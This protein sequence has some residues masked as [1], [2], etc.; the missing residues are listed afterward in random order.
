MSTTTF[1][2][3]CLPEM[4]VSKISPEEQIFTGEIF[5][6]IFLVGRNFILWIV[7]KKSQKLEPKTLKC[8]M[9]MF[10]YNH[11]H[12]FYSL[13]VTYSL[14]YFLKNFN[15]LLSDPFFPILPSFLF[16]FCHNTLFSGTEVGKVCSL[17]TAL[18]IHQKGTYNAK[19]HIS[20]T[21]KTIWNFLCLQIF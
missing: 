8:Q 13:F 4:F 17:E 11:E 19:Y 3:W 15:L 9:V 20:N 10:L 14:Q 7:V 16:I 2:M 21:Q 5:L 1:F 6:G 18:Y 12:W